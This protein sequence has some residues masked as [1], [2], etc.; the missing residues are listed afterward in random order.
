LN[1]DHLGTSEGAVASGAPQEIP[2]H[3][4]TLRRAFF[5]SAT[6]LA[7]AAGCGSSAD[8]GGGETTDTGTGGSDTS[9]TDSG[10]TH[11]SG[12]ATD[13]GAGDSG[14]SDTGK[15]DTGSSSDTGTADSSTTDTATAD[16]SSTDSGSSD[17]AT[18]TDSGAADTTAA[19]S[20]VDTAPVDSGTDAP[21]DTGP[22]LDA[23]CTKFATDFCTEYNT[24]TSFFVDLVWGTESTCETR[25]KIS[26]L[27]LLGA[28]GVGYT[29]GSIISCGAAYKA[30]SCNEFIGGRIPSGCDLAGTYAAGHACGANA[31]CASRFCHIAAGSCGVC[32]TAPTEGAA[33]M[34]GQCAEGMNCIGYSGTPT[35]GTCQ[36]SGLLGDTCDATNDP[37]SANFS[38]RSGHCVADAT[39]GTACSTTGPTA[40]CDVTKGLYCDSPGTNLCKLYGEAAPGAAC[41][42]LATART[43]CTASG[44]CV[45]SGVGS[46]TGTCEAAAADGATCNDTSGPSCMSPAF[47]NASGTC[48]ISDPSSCH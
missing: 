28:P 25:M 10:G 45:A 33:C 44:T 23:A 16:S 4:I 17:T 20:G 11:D 24:C 6:A 30:Q 32:A 5:V 46:T 15:A 14:S 8:T 26:C 2:M 29:P 21:V 34:D 1:I 37:C 31:Q 38:C 36:I 41:G 13:S 35:S 3:S 18:T 40:D 7:L 9:V 19:D 42:A 27:D 48:Q 47:C 43:A 12:T 22:S 39:A